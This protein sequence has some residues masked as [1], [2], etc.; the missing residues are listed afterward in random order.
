MWTVILVAVSLIF[1]IRG[2]VVHF[3]PPPVLLEAP[4]SSFNGFSYL[5]TDSG[6][7]DTSGDNSVAPVET[8]TRFSLPEII[9]NKSGFRTGD[10]PRN[11]YYEDSVVVENQYLPP[12]PLI[13]TTTSTTQRPLQDEPN[14]YLPPTAAN[15]PNKGRHLYYYPKPPIQFDEPFVEPVPAYLPPASPSPPVLQYL[16]PPTTPVHGYLPPS[17]I[18]T[19]TAAT[20]RSENDF[21][22]LLNPARSP[23]RLELVEMKCLSSSPD[24]FF[25]TRI[26]VQSFI[27]TMPVFEDVSGCSH[28]LEIVR[29]QLQ[30]HIPA[31]EFRACGVSACG[32]K[33]EELCTRIRFPQ[34]DRIRTASDAILALQCKQQERIVSRTHALRM[35]VSSDSQARSSAALAQGGGDSKFRIQVGL[36]RRSGDSFTR[37]LDANGVVQL[38]EDLMLR[39]QTRRGDGWNYTKITDITMQ[40]VGAAGEILNTANLVSNNG[41]I[42]PAMKSVCTVPPQ[43]E[44]PLGQKFGFR[45]VMFQGMKSGDEVVMSIRIMGCLSEKDCEP[46]QCN[47]MRSGARIRRNVESG[48]DS[49]RD[50]VEV[51]KISF[52]VADPV[53]EERSFR[54]EATRS[55]IFTWSCVGIALGFFGLAIFCLM[56]I[57]HV[58]N[59]NKEDQ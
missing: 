57:F 51:A 42:N 41:C 59:K 53:N 18:G 23:L 56:V 50:H 21:F 39:M 32:E 5:E 4:P 13:T 6:G 55:L 17:T 36:F 33:N 8:T 9:I 28:R 20:N 7:W 27:N 1:S 45:A 2:D 38:G 54:D 26:T 34:I 37:P 14:Y 44:P 49:D 19:R 35:G 40:R 31:N 46:S 10:V 22:A 29:N 47:L 11:N 58:R 52:R 12:T 16:P 43:Y 24:G 15:K 30:I 3:L 48:R 25:R